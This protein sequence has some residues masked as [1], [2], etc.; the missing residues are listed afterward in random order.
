MLPPPPLKEFFP[1]SLCPFASEK[2]APPS[3]VQHISARLGTP[4]PTEARH[5]SLCYIC[6]RG[7]E[8]PVYALWLVARSLGAPRSPGC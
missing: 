2:A 1:L 7:T 8:Q 6:V 4:S 3:L 5:A